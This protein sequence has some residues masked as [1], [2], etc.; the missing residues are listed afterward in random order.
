MLPKHCAAIVV[1]FFF[2]LSLPAPAFSSSGNM[3]Y[4]KY[5]DLDGK[6]LVMIQTGD[7]G[8]S[9]AQQKTLVQG[10]GEYKREESIILAPGQ[11][12]VMVESDWAVDEDLLRGLSVGSAIM[13]N[14]DLAGLTEKKAEQVFAVKMDSEPGEKGH[15]RQDWSAS[16]QVYEDEQ[17]LGS[18]FVIDQDAFTSGGEMK[19]YIDLLPPGSEV[20]LFEDSKIKGYARITDSLQPEGEDGDNGEQG[21]STQGEA[22]KNLKESDGVFSSTGGDTELFEEANPKE[23]SFILLSDHFETTVPPGTPLEDI[24]LDQTIS[25]AAG[26]FEITGIEVEW[27]SGAVPAYDPDGEGSYVFAGKLSFPDAVIAPGN[28]FLL[29]TVHV[30]EEAKEL[31]AGVPDTGESE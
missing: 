26:L 11:L 13:L 15:L 23:E 30:C 12:D 28:M 20:F 17:D 18:R 7:K 21:D 25:L 9:S 3:R 19:R 2:I 16:E 27:E 5:Y 1:I 10:S 24:E 6:I 4:D 8:S 14:E 22:G 31:E 29:Y